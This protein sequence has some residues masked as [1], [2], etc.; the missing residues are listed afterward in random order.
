M[1][2]IDPNALEPCEDG[3]AVI[4]ERS[5]KSIRGIVRAN[6][7]NSNF[8]IKFHNKVANADLRGQDQLISQSLEFCSHTSCHTYLSHVTF[9]PIPMKVMDQFATP[10]LPRIP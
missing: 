6:Q 8:C 5:I 1:H 10:W 4:Q 9:H 2:M 3:P 7:I